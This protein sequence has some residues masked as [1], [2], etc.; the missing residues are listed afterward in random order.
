M[1][2]SNPVKISPGGIRVIRVGWELSQEKFARVLGCSTSTLKRLE[3]GS[4]DPTVEHVELLYRLKR[5]VE[6]P[7]VTKRVRHALEV[8]GRI[9]VLAMVLR[10]GQLTH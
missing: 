8:S 4:I 6:F 7:R 1:A 2:S 9:E 3:R 5:L 10:N